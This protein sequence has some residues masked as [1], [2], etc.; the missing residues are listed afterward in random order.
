[1][2]RP[3]PLDPPVL[4]SLKPVREPFLSVEIHVV[5]PMFGGG[6]VAGV[7][8]TEFPIH[9]A[10]VRGHLRFWWRACFG[11]RYATATELFRAESEVW[12]QAA[13]REHAYSSPSAV[14]VSMEIVTPGR[15]RPCAISAFTARGTYRAE[16][17][18]GPNARALSYA[19]WPFQ[20]EGSNGAV[21]KQPSEMREGLVFRV[22]FAFASHVKPS[23]MA[24]INAEV[25]AVLWAWVTFGG[26]GAR[27]RRGCGAMYCP[28]LPSL[29]NIGAH[30]VSHAKQHVARG[31][32]TLPVPS[33]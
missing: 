8:D 11:S 31:Q 23:H 13:T 21:T 3:K 1:M 15:T 5:T 24:Q 30:L 20:G 18:L 14:D 28:D 19:L 32:R 33:A 17:K 4:A 10:T 12:G 16:W 7:P 2:P 9:G 29:E 22:N 26:V 6:A 25:H 27:T